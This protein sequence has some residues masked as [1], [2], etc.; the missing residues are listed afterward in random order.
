MLFS[1]P[2]L[3][4]LLSGFTDYHSH[5]LPGVDDGVKNMEGALDVLAHYEQ[6]GVSAVWCTPHIME[7]IPNATDFLRTRFEDLRSAYPG[8]IQLHL[9]SENMMDALFE[10]RLENNDLLPLCEDQRYLL[11]ETSYFNPPMGMKDLLR[12]ILKKGYF[13]VLAHPERYEY[14]NENDYRELKTLGVLFQMNLSSLAGAYGGN[15]KAK[16]EWL[17][18]NEMYNIFGSDLHSLR[19]LEFW[20]YRGKYNKYLKQQIQSIFNQ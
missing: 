7:D 17:L 19:N 8:P 3:K 15:A 9:A 18:K 13:P 11:V 1:R 4:S 12:Q 16:S 14:M 10:E 20:N 2:T 6:I 5:I